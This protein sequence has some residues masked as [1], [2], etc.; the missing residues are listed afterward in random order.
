[1]NC[2]IT[3]KKCLNLA[4][5]NNLYNPMEDSTIMG[6]ELKLPVAVP[7]TSP[8]FSFHSS[9]STISASRKPI[10]VSNPFALLELEDTS[11]DI[12][13]VE[14]IEHEDPL[15][16]LSPEERHILKQISKMITS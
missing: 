2:S 15:E 13:E 3:P 10:P 9:P 6:S 11:S 8:T 1:M 16:H 14:D 12:I 5:N 7:K 4:E